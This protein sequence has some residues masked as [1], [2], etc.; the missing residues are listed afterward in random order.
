[1]FDGS[2]QKCEEYCYYYYYFVTMAEVVGLAASIIQIAGTGAKLSVALYNYTKSAANADPQIR[3]VAD[4]IE[5]TSNVLEN[6]GK[7][8][9]T[10]DVK[11]IVSKKAIQDANNIIKKCEDVFE[12][13]SRIIDK[14]RKSGKDGNK[15]S[16]IVGKLTWPM[17]EP[18]VELHRKRLESLKNSLALLLGVLQLA[19]GQIR[20]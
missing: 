17:K 8:F 7:L 20:G 2:F 10:E 4:D 19:Q 3:D 15:K 18:R 1:V 5:L 13:I 6:V 12:E 9:E 14:R 16:S 11:S